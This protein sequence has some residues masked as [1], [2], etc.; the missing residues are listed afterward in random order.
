MARGFPGCPAHRAPLHPV[1][2]QTHGLRVAAGA[3]TT[4]TSAAPARAAHPEAPWQPPAS[5]PV[6]RLRPHLHR[7]CGQARATRP[8]CR[9]NA[10]AGSGPAPVHPHAAAT[11]SSDFLSRRARKNAGP[12]PIHAP[13]RRLEAALA[14]GVWTM[15]GRTGCTWR[16]TEA[17]TWRQAS[18]MTVSQAETVLP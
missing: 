17:E 3:P 4:P 12:R 18:M 14:Q 11:A 15:A 1:V 2:R 9:D 5:P 10:R 7:T 6:M 13:S 8:H 16:R